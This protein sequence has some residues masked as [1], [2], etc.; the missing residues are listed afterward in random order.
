MAVPLPDGKRGC[1]GGLRSV[2]G[3]LRNGVR[4]PAPLMDRCEGVVGV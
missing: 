4:V 2:M 3:L 1:D